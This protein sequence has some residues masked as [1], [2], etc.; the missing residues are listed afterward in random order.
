[1]K[2]IVNI[3]NRNAVTTIPVRNAKYIEEFEGVKIENKT[4]N[5]ANFLS[6]RRNYK[7]FKEAEV[8]HTHHTFSSLIASMFYTFFIFTKNKRYFVHTLHRN[9]DSF[10]YFMRLV[11]I[12]LIFPFRDKIIANS[13]TT[14]L[15]LKKYITN[16]AFLNTEVI[17]N[18]VK[19]NFFSEISSHNKNLQKIKIVNVGRMVKIKNQKMLIHTLKELRDRN[20]DATIDFCGDGEE[21]NAILDLVVKYKLENFV[22]FHGMVSEQ[23]VYEIL[24]RSN[25]AV[26]PSFNEGFGVATIESMASGIITLGSNIAIHKEIL[27]DKELL[28]SPY[29]PK[30]LSELII[31]FYSHK[32]LYHSKI[33]Y[34]LKRVQQYSAKNTANAHL[35]FYKKLN[36]KI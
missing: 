4:L 36:K 3:I 18:G 13:I 12:F 34:L 14:K 22:K 19:L 5:K 35:L 26:T 24:K 1:M 30:E 10:S 6:F 33:D 15:S 20:Y 27:Q 7:I 25:F 2:G 8:I 16:S 11:Y 21:H 9:F 28:F 29:D 32:N 17:T 31:K 23:K